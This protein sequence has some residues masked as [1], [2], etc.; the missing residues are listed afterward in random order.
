MVNQIPKLVKLSD[1]RSDMN[2]LVC[3]DERQYAE[4]MTNI[5]NNLI[6]ESGLCASVTTLTTPQE[7]SN[8]EFQRYALAFLDIDM[9]RC[10]G[11]DLARQLHEAN[12]NAIIVFVTNY[13][14]YAPAGYEV[15]AFRY[16]LKSSMDE[17][18]PQIFDA[19]ISEYQ[20]MH[21]VV[22]FSVASELIDVPTSNILYLESHQRIIQMHLI[23]S[24]R[25]SYQFYASMTKMTEKLEPMGFLRIQKSYLVNMEYIEYMQ[26]GKVRLTGGTMLTVS[27]KNYAS[28]KRRF[29]S[30]RSKN[31][32]N[33]V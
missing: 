9:G 32:W 22:S 1:R 4:K 26:Y 5:L 2:F 11:I 7:L 21:Q 13:I 19:A 31:R 23:H 20:K 10:N 3:D 8:I 29:S 27:E 25:D 16:M 14:E 17:E 6:D 18:F 12:P 30:W 24:Q 15:K 28:I 33:I